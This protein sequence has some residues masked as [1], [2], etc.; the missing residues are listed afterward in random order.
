MF[1]F[2]FMSEIFFK[3]SL[4]ERLK[5]RKA[6]DVFL[7]LQGNARSL[8]QNLQ[9]HSVKKP[10]F[11][12][13]ISSQ[14]L[15]KWESREHKE[16]LLGLIKELQFYC[17]SFEKRFGLP[18]EASPSEGLF[19]YLL[20]QLEIIY[21]EKALSVN[22][23]EAIEYSLLLLK[24]LFDGKYS[25]QEGLAIMNWALQV[26]RSYLFGGPI[27]NQALLE[28]FFQRIE[29]TKNYYI[30][31]RPEEESGHSPSFYL[32][33]CTSLQPFAILKQTKP[34][35]FSSFE[36]RVPSMKRQAPLHEL[37]RIA[38]EMNEILGLYQYTPMTMEAK[39]SID[40]QEFSGSIQS[41]IPHTFAGRRDFYFSKSGAKELLSLPKGLV[42]T[43]IFE[44]II[45]QRGAG[46]GDNV[47][48]T[49]KA[50]D[51]Q[52]VLDE[53]FAI[54]LEEI[55]P[56]YLRLKPEIAFQDAIAAKER[57]CE[58]DGKLS[59]KYLTLCRIW[60]MGLPQAAKPM[61]RAIF[62]MGAHPALLS[63]T[64]DYAD[65]LLKSSSLGKEEIQ[66]LKE[67]IDLIHEISET[68]LA[69][70]DLISARE[71]YFK[72]FGGQEIYDMAIEAGLSP[73]VIFD[74]VLGNP[75]VNFEDFSKPKES[76]KNLKTNYL[77]DGTSSEDAKVM[78]E[79]FKTLL[80]AEEL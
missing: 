12:G 42:H 46:H 29:Q 30:V 1:L 76:L 13:I 62:M 33:D 55:M 6:L 54:D 41:Y 38:Y 61:S 9:I 28:A 37:E 21:Q 8:H 2:V 45:Q 51:G 36:E 34:L 69:G 52:T 26:T 24:E 71:L 64:K 73:I 59:Y 31:K 56:R 65:L 22:A 79:N 10:I 63:V 19:L 17:K 18:F 20:E 60:L 4:L 53:I 43:A 7:T 15:Q 27:E 67:R 68:L 40:G 77:K 70:Q 58:E 32:I 50:Q 75:Y 80:D 44:A 49:K 66:G 47:I 3:K 23:L 35:Y 72:I 11:A 25:L 14:V 48:F 74:Q 5:F 39:F 16:R 78:Q 57:L